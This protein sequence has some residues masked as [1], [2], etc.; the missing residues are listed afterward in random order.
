MTGHEYVE[1]PFYGSANPEEYLQWVQHME[2]ELQ[3]KKLTKAKEVARATMEFEEY[4]YDWWKHHPSKRF[5]ASWD[6]LKI[7]M[8]E[9]FV[10][11]D[12]EHELLHQV[13]SIKQGCQSV[14][15]Y[16]KKLN[17]AMHR[18]NVMN[19][20][21]ARAYFKQGLNPEISTT[22]RLKY[23]GSMQDLVN[24][25]IEE[26]ERVK[27][28]HTPRFNLG[29]RLAPS[30]TKSARFTLRVSRAEKE[31]EAPNN[32]PSK[33]AKP[34]SQKEEDEP[35]TIQE[36]PSMVSEVRQEMHQNPM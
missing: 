28:P 18:A 29:Q 21:E 20:S 8:R 13:K 31:E 15:A 1:L 19:A 6:E 36:T 24:F 10:P 23:N 16:Y 14:Q 34:S 7:I 27:K 3:S 17:R 30:S 12:Y 32:V 4:A 35:L 11:Y 5:L 25:A 9:E 22:V 2:L 26:E 33:E